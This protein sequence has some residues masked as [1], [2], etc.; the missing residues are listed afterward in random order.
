MSTGNPK[1]LLVVAVKSNPLPSGEEAVKRRLEALDYEV[2]VSEPTVAGLE[3]RDL[4]LLV[5]SS[6]VKNQ[7]FGRQLRDLVVPII[8]SSKELYVSL[9]MCSSEGVGEATDQSQIEIIYPPNPGHPMTANL[10]GIV[11]ISSAPMDL[12]WAKNLHSKSAPI[13]ALPNTSTGSTQSWLKKRWTSLTRYLSSVTR[14]ARVNPPAAPPRKHVLFGCRVATPMFVAQSEKPSDFPA[15]RVAFPFDHRKEPSEELMRLFDAAANWAVGNVNIRQF[16]EVFR[17]EWREIYTRRKKAYAQPPQQ[18]VTGFDG[19]HAP[20]NLVG[21]A[22]SGGGIRSATF[23]LG[24]LQALHEL[25]LLRIFDYL[26]TV[27]GGGYLGGWWSAWLSR[28]EVDD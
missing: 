12:S 6:R 10:K 20:E 3:V 25:K 27:S 5:V 28:P 21:L 4:A 1:A 24:V 2:S 16:A 18:D 13:A 8:A 7:A 11:R 23:C 14:R 19:K 15:K 22:F 26:S 17:E 9:G